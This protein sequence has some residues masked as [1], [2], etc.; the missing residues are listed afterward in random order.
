[1]A[2]LLLRMNSPNRTPCPSGVK[3]ML[4]VQVASGAR[5]LP[6]LL[7]WIKSPVTTMLVTLIACPP[8]LVRVMIWL[9][10]APPKMTLP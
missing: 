1:M 10:V 2:E 8:M 3:I 6:Q 5:L 9:G 7:V 4:I